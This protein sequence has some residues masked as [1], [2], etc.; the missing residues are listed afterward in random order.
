MSVSFE[1][2]AGPPRSGGRRSRAMAL[3]SASVL[4]I[5][6]VLAVPASAAPREVAPSIAA[7]LSTSAIRVGWP[8]YVSGRVDPPGI[9]SQ[10]IVQRLV[11]S[12]WSDRASSGP[13]A[14]DGTFKVQITPSE[15]GTYTLRVRS[16]GGNLI[17][18]TLKLTVT[19]VPTISASL[20]LSSVALGSPATVSGTVAPRTA[21]SRVVLQR[22]VNGVWS[23]RGTASVN[24]SNGSYRLPLT[25]SQETTYVLRVVSER[26]SVVSRVLRLG[27]FLRASSMVQT[28]DALPGERVVA[29]TFGDGPGPTYTS[30][31]LDV[32]ARH[33]VKATFFM[34]GQ[35]ASRYPDTVRRVVREGHHI[36]NHSW[37]HPSLTSLSDAGVRGEVGGTDS[38]L[39]SL[40]AHPRCVRPP[41]GANSSRVQSIISEYGSATMLWTIDPSDWER[42]A[43]STIAARVMSHLHPGAVILLHDGGGS[44]GNTVA[45]LDQLIPQI[46][47]AGYQIRT[48]C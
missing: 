48:S 24:S 13:L 35:N 29:L 6:V 15:V 44:R 46:K 40:G 8:A 33:K 27:V 10:V 1:D 39:R 3:V 12:K 16:A 17:S 47:A 9:T 32:L 31:V 2:Q 23:D 20:N 19:P 34:L 36:G 42:P 18:P 38:K 37:S 41:Y 5:A 30:Q 14:A 11:G 28:G 25:A 45:A 7:K 22:L 43:P 26:K 4:A 21:T